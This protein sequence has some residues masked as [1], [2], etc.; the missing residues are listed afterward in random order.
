M[1]SWITTHNGPDDKRLC[2]LNSCNLTPLQAGVS[3]VSGVQ[4]NLTVLIY[5]IPNPEIAAAR[6]YPT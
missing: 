1:Q 5:P 3:G 4:V 2:N 6:L